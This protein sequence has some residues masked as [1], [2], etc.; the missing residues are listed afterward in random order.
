MFNDVNEFG[1]MKSMVAKAVAA[2][3]VAAKAATAAAASV[4]AAGAPPSCRYRA[5]VERTGC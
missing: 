3:A 5:R 4:H 2:K 1:D